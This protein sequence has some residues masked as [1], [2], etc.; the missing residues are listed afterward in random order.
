MPQLRWLQPVFDNVN[1]KQ[2]A[3][4][5]PVSECVFLFRIIDIETC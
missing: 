3:E 1:E 4:W 5:N 2:M